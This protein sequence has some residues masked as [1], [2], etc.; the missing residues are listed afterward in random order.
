MA[1]YTYRLE[2]R[3]KGTSSWV[4][5]G[6]GIPRDVNKEMTHTLAAGT[7]TPGKTYE[8]RWVRISKD[9]TAT[10]L[11]NS[12]VVEAFIDTS[13]TTISGSGTVSTTGTF[14][15]T[16]TGGGNNEAVLVRS[17]SKIILQLTANWEY[18][19]I[20]SFTSPINGKTQYFAKKTGTYSDPVNYPED[21]SIIAKTTNKIVDV[22]LNSSY[23]Y[24]IY[25]KFNGS[26]S[27]TIQ[28]NAI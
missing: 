4:L 14:L 21:T 18:V 15:V 2:Y 23:T 22:K 28:V 1:D 20:D 12:N 8:F 19:R 5:G 17:A 24:R 9:G 27:G 7:L 3:E 13:V 25:I 6:S 16:A 11:A 26:S 10:P